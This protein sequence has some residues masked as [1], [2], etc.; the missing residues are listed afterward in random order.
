M[1]FSKLLLNT[2]PFAVLLFVVLLFFYP[3]WLQGRVS[4]PA[5]FVVGTYF[6]WLDY[7]WGYEVGVPVKNPITTDVVS[8]IYPMQTLAIDLLKAGQLPLWNPYILGG[9]PL[10]ANFQSAPFSIT[11]F[12][13]FIFEKLSAW[14]LQIILQ[15]VL[16][17]VF[18]YLLLR[19]WRVSVLGSVFAGIAF[20]FS[21][22]NLLWSQWNGH[23]LS[24]AFIPLILL[25][26]DKWFLSGRGIFGIGLSISIAVQ[27][28][29]GYPQIMLYSFLAMGILWIV[30]L[31][32]SIAFLKR[33]ILMPF[34]GLLG[35]GLSAF[36]ILPGA[37]L[38]S[39]S[40]RG[41]ELHPYEWA[42][43]PFLKV[44]TFFAPDF[45][46]NHATANYWGPQ[47]YT[48]NT[49][50][51]GVV[52]GILAGL[53]LAVIRKQRA[54]LFGFLL[55]ASALIFAFP[56]PLAVLI[57]KSG[58]LGLQAASAHRV[59]ILFNFAV[60]ILAGFGVDHFLKS[61]KPDLKYGF[62]SPYIIVFGFLLVTLYL[63][64][65]TQGTEMALLRGIPLYLVG[66]RNLV[67]PVGVLI[68]TTLLIFLSARL[69]SIKKA[70]IVL[71]FLVMCFE[72]FRFGWKFTPFSSRDIVFPKTPVIDFLLS[73]EKPVRTT[74]AQVVPSNLRMPYGLESLEGYDAVYPLTISRF[75][76]SIN[77]QS[78]GVVPTGRYGTVD[79]ITS[80]LMDLVNTK[81]YL[82]VK[83]DNKNVPSA[84]GSV[85]EHFDP[86]RFRVAFED[87]SVAVLESNKTLSRAFMVYRW[88]VIKNDTEILDRLLDPEFPRDKKI[89]LEEPVLMDQFIKTENLDYKVEHLA[90][91]SQESTL[92]VVTKEEGML[93][94]S[95]TF[96]PGWKALVDGKEVK[97]YRANFN[98]RA[99][100]I[101][102][103][104]HK[105]R[106]FYQPDSFS[107]G[108][109]VSLFSLLI[110]GVITILRFVKV[111]RY[112]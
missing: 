76:A 97:I 61:K 78:A 79:N 8:F 77:A 19:H 63:F 7:K 21:G 28:L 69:P 85:S 18:T 13:Y 39:L 112:A 43:L 103:G 70:T 11:N 47:D 53:S 27:M 40:Q 60:A 62:I 45:F 37:E 46:G 50:F 89:I 34:F 32:K 33:T 16:A 49:G 101:P 44:I 17:A 22:F 75:I 64:F 2:F 54:A 68:F 9:T 42:F 23:T 55:L 90:Y 51:I 82:T 111:G 99:I 106:F 38:L 84:Q 35:L 102:A 4:L 74:G 58:I 105:V 31:E 6:P 107:R 52:A 14:S 100:P 109:K 12:L 24:A 95:D 25:F 96:Y 80:N 1:K 91:G 110:I 48:S 30:R 93:F 3:V 15:H 20:A 98:F 94:V 65:K 57:W 73:Q 92:R 29:S 41:V 83:K 26:Q 5:D 86:E 88:E 108:L 67:I 36:Q 56:T 72:M 10:L 81:Y 71:L 59:L 66:L 87:K 104:T